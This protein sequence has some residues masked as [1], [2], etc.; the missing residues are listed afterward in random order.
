MWAMPSR[1]LP[2]G[3]ALEALTWKPWPG[4]SGNPGLGA[5]T[6][7]PWPGGP[8]LGALAW[9]PWPGGPDLG[10]LA[11]GPEGPGWV[12]TGGRA[13]KISPV[14]YREKEKEEKQEEKQ[15]ENKKKKDRRRNF[16]RTF[17]KGEEKERP[18]IPERKS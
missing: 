15:E 9:G 14:F 2:E 5:L 12:R 17:L 11:W 13:D 7:G 4:G 18:A 6:W 3:P 1:C 8:G 16:E 10:A